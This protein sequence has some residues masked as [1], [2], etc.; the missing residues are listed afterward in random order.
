MTA[1]AEDEVAEQTALLET[2]QSNAVRACW[3]TR[4]LY[5]EPD[6]GIVTVFANPFGLADGSDWR[7]SSGRTTGR[8]RSTHGTQD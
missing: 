6:S 2:C 5:Q 4:D 3:P 7:T 1:A 8:D